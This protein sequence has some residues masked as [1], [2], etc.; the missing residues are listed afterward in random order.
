ML[1]YYSNY[2]Y[3]VSYIEHSNYIDT[4]I[5]HQS[6]TMAKTKQTARKETGGKKPR[7]QLSTKESHKGAPKAGGFS[8]RKGHLPRLREKLIDEYYDGDDLKFDA[9][10]TLNYDSNNEDPFLQ[11]RKEADE[12]HYNKLL[13]EAEDSRESL[14]LLLEQSSLENNP[15]K[16][17]DLAGHQFSDKHSYAIGYP[18]LHEY[19]N[20]FDT[21]L[22]R[23]N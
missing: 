23:S 8:H 3:F 17:H 20:S 11:K 13:K 9:K 12:A 5:L 22:R 1:I 4:R 2:S 15:P 10:N 16:S 14:E 18:S 6:S 21:N 7:R 19:G